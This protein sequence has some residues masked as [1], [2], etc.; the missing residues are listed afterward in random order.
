MAIV[1]TNAMWLLKGHALAELD[2]DSREWRW[3]PLDASEVD[4]PF[5]YSARIECHALAGYKTVLRLGPSIGIT[6]EYR[7]SSSES[8]GKPC[9]TTGG[10]NRLHSSC[11]FWPIRG[12]QWTVGL[13]GWARMGSVRGA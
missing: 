12:Y 9:G 6:S 2:W 4:V 5:F 1:A 13:H 8:F 3:L 11:D 10:L 7:F